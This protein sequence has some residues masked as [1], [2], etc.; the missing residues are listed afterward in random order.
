MADLFNRILEAIEGPEHEFGTLGA[1]AQERLA[2]VTKQITED[3]AELDDFREKLTDWWNRETTQRLITDRARGRRETVTVVHLLDSN[4]VAVCG[5]SPGPGH[6]GST[7][8]GAVTCHP[9]LVVAGLTESE[10]RS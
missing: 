9:C 2:A 10:P 1:D 3:Y 4:R 5:A 8:A 7:S 6:L